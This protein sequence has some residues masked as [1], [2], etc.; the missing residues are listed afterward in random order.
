MGGAARKEHASDEHNRQID[1]RRV[2]QV[3]AEK[4][5]VEGKTKIRH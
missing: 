4:E 3:A 5:D 2:L 1:T